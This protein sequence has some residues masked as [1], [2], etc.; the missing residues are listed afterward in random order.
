MKFKGKDFL[1][2]LTAIFVIGIFLIKIPLLCADLTTDIA[3]GDADYLTDSSKWS[4]L[5]LSWK[6]SILNTGVFS[7]IDSFLKSINP[8]F[9]VLFGDPYSLSFFFFFVVIL[10][11]WFFSQF[12]KVFG[13]MGLFSKWISLIIGFAL[14]VGVAQLGLFGGLSK[15][16]VKLIFVPNK[17]WGGI[18]FFFLIIF[19]L[20][21]ISRLGKMIEK[22]AEKG[23]EGLEKEK[24]KI[25][26]SF[27]DTVTDSMKKWFKQE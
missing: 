20:G 24:E 22:K 27:L 7:G 5:T 12:R 10:W 17:P 2:I 25:N 9:S 14:T 19:I 6:Q 11:F 26:R 15:L 16:F 4:N 23:R 1:F 18:V 21:F 3:G 13:L 8:F